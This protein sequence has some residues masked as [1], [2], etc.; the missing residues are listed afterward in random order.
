MFL[1]ETAIKAGLKGKLQFETET[2]L[3]SKIIIREEKYSIPRYA[4][5]SM[6]TRLP[7]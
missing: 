3:C 4:T 6:L 1:T 7:T 5:L 2:V